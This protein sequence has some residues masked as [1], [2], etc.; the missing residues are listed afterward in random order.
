[1]KALSAAA[2][3]HTAGQ[4][5]LL[6]LLHRL[7]RPRPPASCASA[8]HRRQT[9]SIP[10]CQHQQDH[11]HADVSGYRRAEEARLASLAKVTIEP[12]N[13]NG[14]ELPR[15]WLAEKN[16]SR[17]PALSADTASERDDRRGGAHRLRP[18]VQ[19][20]HHGE[21]DEDHGRGDDRVHQP[22]HAHQH[23]LAAAETIRPVAMKV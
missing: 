10:G 5:P 23:V 6:N 4:Y 17:S 1:M 12:T 2:R 18:A 20:L 22:Q 15:L 3:I 7:C 21:R 8:F 16:C 19:A 14:E 11:D 13:R 9:S